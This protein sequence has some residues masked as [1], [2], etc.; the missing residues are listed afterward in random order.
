MAESLIRITL[1][2]VDKASGTFKEIGTSAKS[3]EGNVEQSYAGLDRNYKKLLATT[4]KVAAGI[5]AATLAAKK[6]WDFAEEGA[7]VNRLELATTKLAATMDASM[8]NIVADIRSASLNT[9]SEYEAMQAAGNAMM[10][11]LGADSEK[12]SNLMQIA[13]FRGRAMGLSTAQAFSDIVR[14]VGRLSPLILDNLGI[15]I[16]A[17]STYEAHALAVGKTTGELT[18]MEKRQALLNRVLAEGNV[19]MGQAGGLA[20][21]TAAAYERANAA[22]KDWWNSQKQGWADFGLRFIT[23]AQEYND[24]QKDI[25]QTT[26]ENTGNYKD[27]QTASLR[28][29]SAL[30]RA[31]KGIGYYVDEFGNLHKRW[32]DFF[33]DGTIYR[34]YDE[35]IKQNAVLTRGQYGE[36]ERLTAQANAYKGL[37]GDIQNV[38]EETSGYNEELALQAGLS[39]ELT[40]AQEKYFETLK[41]YGKNSARTKSEIEDLRQTTNKF[42]YDLINANESIEISANMSIQLGNSLGLI[43]EKS[44]LASKAL[45]VLNAKYDKN[46]DGILQSS[47]ITQEYI[48]DVALLN[49]NAQALMV[50]RSATWSIRVL[51]NGATI[52]AG[53]ALK[54]G[55]I[56]TKQFSAI[57]GIAGGRAAGGPIQQGQ[58]YW[59]GERGPELIVPNSSG[60]VIPN[61][62][63]SG[64]GEG[65]VVLKNYGKVEFVLGKDGM[66]ASDLM[67]QLG[68]L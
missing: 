61:N 19:L 34:H 8:S 17:N 31:Q 24:I 43:D 14:G 4:T 11:G 6:A 42:L 22:W 18:S 25:A 15:V 46:A 39:N 30:S 35:I 59:V 50:D 38:V 64:G 12:L 33:Q 20:L 5:T 67:Q 49:Q 21:D 7:Q 23:T 63:I 41:K 1:Q 32:N 28:A 44:L 27:Y 2:A 45:D 51:L 9:I 29:V 48:D 56:N 3:L 37:S 58:P 47:E 53:T 65:G 68:V 55:L 54:M 52:P 60:T 13:A 36:M 26:K 57:E 10:L 62:K 16:D 40:T 66:S